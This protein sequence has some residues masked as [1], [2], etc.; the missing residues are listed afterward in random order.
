LELLR[1]LPGHPLPALAVLGFE[2][3]LL[4]DSGLAPDPAATR[5]SPAGQALL[6]RLSDG[7]S[8]AAGPAPHAAAVVEVKRF[9]Q[10]FLLHHLGRVPPGRAAALG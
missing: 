1:A 7:E 10:G 2:V 9:L 8:T 3:Q 5:L 4:A 6:Q